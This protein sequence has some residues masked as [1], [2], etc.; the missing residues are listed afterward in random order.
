MFRILVID[1]RDSITKAIKYLLYRYEVVF[2]RDVKDAITKLKDNII[3]MILVNLPFPDGLS[4]SC[5]TLKEWIQRK[6]T[7][8]IADLISTELV[9]EAKKLGAEICIDKLEIPRLPELVGRFL[10]QAETKILN[11]QG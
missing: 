8:V 6:K 3:D 9:D 4:S 11:L 5:E 10:N 1:N 2:S 7:I